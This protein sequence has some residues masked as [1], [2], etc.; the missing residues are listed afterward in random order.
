MKFRSSAIAGGVAV[1]AFALWGC[2]AAPAPSSSPIVPALRETP[3]VNASGD[4]A[5]DP[6]IWVAPEPANS[7]VLGTQ[8]KGGLYVYNLTGEIVQTI[9]GGR[10]NNVDL[11]PGFPWTD[12]EGPLVGASDR[13]DNTLVVWRLDPARGRLEPAP[14]ARIATGFA[15]VYG[16]CLGR[17]GDDFIAVATDKNSG[18][19]GVWRVFEGPDGV[20][21]G[22]RIAEF[23]IGSITEGCV[24]DD[25]R[26]VFYLADE[27]HGVWEVPLDAADGAGRRMVDRVGGD[28]HLAADVEGL[29]LWLG[30]EGRGYLVASVQGES[31][32]AVYDR[33]PPHAYRGSFAI[34]PARD[35]AA[36]G[37]SGT[38]GV[39]ITSA[40]LGSDFPAGL[41]VVQDDENT[42][43]AA[44]QNFKFVSWAEIAS[45]LDL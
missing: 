4:A 38:D 36:D 18:D 9:P 5:D 37:V 39:D 12:G 41:M 32:Y 45:L 21:V 25:A 8:K 42:S 1:A 15:E 3:P 28:G 11:R 34:G 22:D 26:G 19:V 33:A 7:L 43:P 10:P 13:S 6:A 44:A 35:G 20:P 40:P 23:S 14:A 2:Q 27:L 17:R 29:S 31:R 30:D 16:F 24:V